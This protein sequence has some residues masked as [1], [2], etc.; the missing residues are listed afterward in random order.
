MMG[1]FGSVAFYV[2]EV[3]FERELMALTLLPTMKLAR[4]DISF[5]VT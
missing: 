5:V 2:N 4:Q 1:V 3:T